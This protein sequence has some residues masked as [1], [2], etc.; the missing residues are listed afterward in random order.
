[1]VGDE[2]KANDLRLAVYIAMHSSIRSVD[3]LTELLKDLGKGSSLENLRMH[4][5]KCSKLIANVISPALLTDLVADVGSGAFSLILDESTDISTTKYLAI[6]IKYYSQ[7]DNVMKTDFLGLLEVY[8]ATASALFGAVCEY[9]T[10]IGLN[11]KNAIGLGSD[12]GSNLCGQHNSV[13]ALFKAE[14]R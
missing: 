7:K 5:T 10:Q 2:K 8:R 9:L 4:R 13:Y 6:M 11:Y 3:H 1:M 14:V 12:G